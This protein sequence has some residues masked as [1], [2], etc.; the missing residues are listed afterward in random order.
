MLLL[1]I[2]DVLNSMYETTRCCSLCAVAKFK[3]ADS[4]CFLPPSSIFSCAVLSLGS[5]PHLAS[6]E[7]IEVLEGAQ[8]SGCIKV[9]PNMIHQQGIQ[10][11]EAFP[12]RKSPALITG[13]LRCQSGTK[14]MDELE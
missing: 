4:S 5:S 11:I 12:E 1:A 7:Q 10:N 6:L 3:R 2:L 8:A 14:E 13:R 9:E